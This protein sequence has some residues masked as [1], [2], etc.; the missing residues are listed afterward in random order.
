M[1]WRWVGVGQVPETRKGGYGSL[2]WVLAMLGATLQS[3][4]GWLKWLR[5]HVVEHSRSCV[6]PLVSYTDDMQVSALGRYLKFLRYWLVPVVAHPRRWMALPEMVTFHTAA[7]APKSLAPAAPRRSSRSS[8]GRYR[9]HQCPCRCLAQHLFCHGNVSHNQRAWL[10]LL[11]CVYYAAMLAGCHRVL[12]PPASDVPG[13]GGDTTLRAAQG[14]GTDLCLTA[15]V[16]SS[17]TCSLS[18]QGD[19]MNGRQVQAA[20][21]FRL[22]CLYCM[23]M[24]TGCAS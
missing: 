17:E 5:M 1:I 10:T 23:G 21:F 24:K 8:P 3:G 2:K 6:V 14:T 15:Y 13:A 18:K 11:Y 19:P 22:F 20:V 16:W 4:I 7:C 9:Q 12:P